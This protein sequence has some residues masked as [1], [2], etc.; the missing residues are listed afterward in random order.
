MFTY[1]LWG[2]SHYLG[3]PAKRAKLNRPDKGRHRAEPIHSKPLVCNLE[4]WIAFIEFSTD[5]QS[6]FDAVSGQLG[7]C[8]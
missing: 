1:Y 6:P 3:Y 7:L 2:T 4:M 8:Q 5:V